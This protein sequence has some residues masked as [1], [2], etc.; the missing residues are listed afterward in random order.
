MKKN[1][2]GR[3]LMGDKPKVKVSLFMDEHLVQLLKNYRKSTG[4]TVSRFIERSVAEAMRS[5]CNN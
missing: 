3:P 5:E 4:I 2:V 1:K